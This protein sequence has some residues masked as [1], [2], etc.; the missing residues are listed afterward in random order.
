VAD[1]TDPIPNAALT[2]AWGVATAW[3]AGVAVAAW[4]LLGWASAAF[5]DGTAVPVGYDAFYHARR[6]I[7]ASADLAGLVEFERRMHYPEGSWIN[8]PWAFDWTLAGLLAALRSQFPDLP[9]MWLL[10]FVPPLALV[11]N[12]ALL[13]MGGRQLGLSVPMLLAATLCF[14]LSP[15]VAFNHTF[16]AVDH[17]FAE[18]AMVLATLLLALRWLRMPTSTGRALALGLLLGL[19]PGV[20]N[21]MFFLQGIVLAALGLMWISNCLPARRTVAAF[22]LAQ[23]VAVVLVVLPSEP[24]WRAPPS[25]FLLGGFHVLLCAGALLVLAVFASGPPSPRR[26]AVLVLVSLGGA[27]LFA[28]QLE[29][30]I[31]WTR[32]DLDYLR[33][34]SEAQTF[35]GLWRNSGIEAA[36]GIYSW[37]PLGV[38][39]ALWACMILARRQPAMAALLVVFV[40]AGALMFALQNRFWYVGI[41][42]VLLAV[43]VFVDA[44]RARTLSPIAHGL[45]AATLACTA[46]ATAVPYITLR[47]P[48]GGDSR[49]ARMHVA[50][51]SLAAACRAAPGVVLAERNLGHYISYA[52]DCSVIGNN[53]ILTDQHLRKLDETAMLLTL[54]L[55]HLRRAEPPID[56][57][58]VSLPDNI[59]ADRVAGRPVDLTRLAWPSLALLQDAARPVDGFE[60]LFD[61]RARAAAPS[62]ADF[63]ACRVYR[64][65]PPTSASAG[66]EYTY[67]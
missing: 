3:A 42:P 61:V 52:T 60:L 15:G 46:F 20:H 59:F 49:Y 29:L 63:A 10:A 67:E 55:A 45:V 56:Y 16:G 25:L 31:S 66:M 34:I 14:A 36:L 23:L 17:H 5:I 51:A 38:P 43:G 40:V 26:W 30:G 21:G 8:W 47:L 57:L 44:L 62:G 4:W 6:I 39:F 1:R 37:W 2:P 64:I 33:D 11:G 58:I 24:F 18:A 53:F 7:D 27:A 65:N 9:P 35:V 13:A 54:P 12:L 22:G 28:P 48:I 50:L 19:A 32:G 41:P